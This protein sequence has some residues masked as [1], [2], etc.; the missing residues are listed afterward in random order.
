MLG[1]HDRPRLASRLG[2]AQALVAAVLLLTLRGTPT[3]YY[4][5]ELGLRDVAVAPEHVQDP[6]EK[7]VPGQG[8]GRDPV[9][10]PMPW[11]LE[12]NAGFCP[13]EAEPW[14][15]AGSRRGPARGHA[16]SRPR[17]SSTGA[18]WRC[19][20][21]SRRSRSATARAASADGVLAY[22]RG[23]SILVALNLTGEERTLALGELAGE[24]LLSARGVADGL[25]V[26]GSLGLAGD[27]AV[28]VRLG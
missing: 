28:I 23:D 26:S 1:N 8:L 22:L 14:L 9:R 21:P 6:W 5:D 15:P 19:A 10:A 2:P 7:R 12:A 25:R 24:V 27:D 17:S 4:G 20:A 13:P 3:L 11:T 16:R 18:C